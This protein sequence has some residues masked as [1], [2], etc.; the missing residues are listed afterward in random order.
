MGSGRGS[1]VTF[2]TTNSAGA[3]H[4]VSGRMVAVLSAK[5]WFGIA[6]F[7][8]RGGRGGDRQVVGVGLAVWG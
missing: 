3:G 2:L 5:G 8:G 7:W 6:K 4:A 1:S